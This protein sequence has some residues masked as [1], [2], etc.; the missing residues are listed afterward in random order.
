MQGAH[1]LRQGSSLFPLLVRC[2]LQPFLPPPQQAQPTGLQLLHRVEVSQKPALAGLLL[3]NAGSWVPEGAGQAQI[4]HQ[5]RAALAPALPL[6]MWAGPELPQMWG[7]R[8]LPLPQ[9]AFP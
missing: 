4:P 3:R 7:M 5:L 9:M 1:S 8:E 2:S 6:Q